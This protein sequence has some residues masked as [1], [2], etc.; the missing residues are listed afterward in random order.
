METSG[1]K[2]EKPCQCKQEDEEQEHALQQTLVEEEEE[3]EEALSLRDLPLNS[4]QTSATATS[5]SDHQDPVSELFEFLGFATCDVSP[6]ENIIFRGKLIPLNDQN[7]LRPDNSREVRTN[8]SPRIRVRS[9][10]LS[11]LQGDKLSRS[12]SVPRVIRNCRSLDCRKL[13]CV[14]S[15]EKFSTLEHDRKFPEKGSPP[16]M[17]KFA[18]APAKNSETGSFGGKTIRPRWYVFMFGMVKFPPAIE[19]RDIKIRQTRRNI[20]PVMF[21]SSGDRISGKSSPS[22]ASSWRFLKALSCKEP[23][24]AAATAPFWVPNA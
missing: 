3:E 5:A 9:E 11:A 22:S 19:L 1:N 4:D 16:E 14:T 7:N 20:P 18:A 6:A 8:P 2:E 10:S 13:T 15:N 24:S 12:S 21:P 17:P 23:T